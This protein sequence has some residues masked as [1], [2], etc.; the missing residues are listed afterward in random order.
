MM[1]T[2]EMEMESE[3][4]NLGN[5]EEAKPR[6]NR[7]AKAASRATKTKTKKPARIATKTRSGQKI[8]RARA[9][10]AGVLAGKNVYVLV[11]RVPPK[12]HKAAWA[13]ARKSG[14]SLNSWLSGAVARAAS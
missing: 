11:V 13:K 8:A 2:A 7:A 10:Q 12:L 3:G 6:K 1:A 14:L 4:N 5:P 9:G